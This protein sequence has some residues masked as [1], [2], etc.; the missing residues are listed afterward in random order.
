MEAG[1]IDD[2]SMPARWVNVEEERE[3]QIE[4]KGP[5]NNTPFH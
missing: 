5:Y 4:G 2:H 3:E 1:I